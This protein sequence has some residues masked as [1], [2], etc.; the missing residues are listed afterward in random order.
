MVIESD[1]VPEDWISAVFVPLYKG[2][3]ER[4]LNLGII[5]VLTCKV[6]FEKY[7]QQYL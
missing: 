5:E 6:W 7:I 4:E 3:G 2:K 1:V